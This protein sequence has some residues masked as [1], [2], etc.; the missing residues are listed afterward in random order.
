[1]ARR[2]SAFVPWLVG[3]WSLSASSWV[4]NDFA[5]LSLGGIGLVALGVAGSVVYKNGKADVSR[6][7]RNLASRKIQELEKELGFEPINFQELSDDEVNRLHEEMR[8]EKG[9]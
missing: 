8:K 9:Q 1:V 5:R 4:D 6:F 3:V 7:K 2:K